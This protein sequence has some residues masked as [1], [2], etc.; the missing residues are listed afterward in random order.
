MVPDVMARDVENRHHMGTVTTNRA[1]QL[2]RW[3]FRKW[4]R[5][6]VSRSVTCP[7]FRF[8]LNQRG[9]RRDP[10]LAGPGDEEAAALHE[11]PLGP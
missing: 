11:V 8:L 4:S 9:L 2:Q 6:R 7:D 10:Q 3:R 5:H 1:F